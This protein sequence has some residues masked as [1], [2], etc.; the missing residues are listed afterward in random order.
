MKKLF[1]LLL[2][3]LA[4]TVGSIWLLCC[5]LDSFWQKE[6]N[7]FDYNS[8]KKEAYE[9]LNDNIDRLDELAKNYLENHE[10][11][12]TKFKIVTYISYN[13]TDGIRNK[14]LETVEFS[15]DSQGML[16]GQ[17][18]GLLYIP[19]NNY[20]GEKD[21]YIYDEH[22]EKGNGNNIFIRE[23]LKENWFF[24]YDDYDG[25]VDTKRINKSKEKR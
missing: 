11:E 8:S 25:K 10:L 17:Y 2:I 15:C 4:I 16:G 23:K 5:Y 12:S 22:K 24:F 21:L 7:K 9:F 20:L 3:A 14:P 19:A 13:E 6:F 1:K 18:W